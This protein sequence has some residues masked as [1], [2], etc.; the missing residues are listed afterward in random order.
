D[1]GGRSGIPEL[2]CP[3]RRRRLH[4]P[5][6]C[7]TSWQGENAEDAGHTDLALL[8]MNGVA[9]RADVRSGTTGSPQ[10]LGSAQWCSLGVV[11][12]FNAIPAA[13]L[14]HVFAEQLPGL[15][16][17]QANIQLIPLHS[18]HT[19]DPARRRAVVGGFDFDAA[20]QMHDALAVLVVAKRF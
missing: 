7:R 15:G 5:P 1:S 18:K 17:E 6:P 20:I 3:A 13:L 2:P 11:L 12:F 8:A 10:Q 4:R 9:E 16:I 14:A 19:T